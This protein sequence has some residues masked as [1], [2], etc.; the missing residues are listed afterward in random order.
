[1]GGGGGGR[2]SLSP[3][4][5]AREPRGKLEAGGKA[6]QGKEQE[7]GVG[8]P[9]GRPRPILAVA[10]G[11]RHGTQAASQGRLLVLGKE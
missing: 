6:P 10:P 11:G 5:A 8:L 2:R 1:M 3:T 9:W 7:E 4:G